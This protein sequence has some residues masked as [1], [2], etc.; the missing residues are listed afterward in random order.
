MLIHKMRATEYNRFTKI[1]VSVF[2]S[3][4]TSLIELVKNGFETITSCV[5]EMQNLNILFP[6][7]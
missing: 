2:I 4:Q 6:Q 7:K 3:L 5:A 1:D